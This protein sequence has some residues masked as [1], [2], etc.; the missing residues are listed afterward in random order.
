MTDTANAGERDG[1]TKDEESPPL[2]V[3]CPFSNG[4]YAE[5]S[6]CFSDHSLQFGELQCVHEAWS[7]RCAYCGTGE[8]CFTSKNG[9]YWLELYFLRALPREGYPPVV[10]RKIDGLG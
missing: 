8:V 4:H 6:L 5:A 2:A 3:R 1:T 7:V 9:S 10:T